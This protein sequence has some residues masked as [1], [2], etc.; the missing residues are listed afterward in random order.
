MGTEMRDPN[1]VTLASYNAKAREYITGSPQEVTGGLKKFIDA[2][3][4]D[5][6]YGS[7]VLEVEAGFGRDAL[8]LQGKGFAVIPTDGAQSFVKELQQ[9]GL[10]AYE[11]NI[12]EDSFP[13]VDV[14]FANAVFLH[15][16]IEELR[17]VLVKSRQALNL[18]GKLI[19]TVK[20]GEGEEFSEEKLDRPRYFAYWNVEN[21]TAELVRAGFTAGSISE[22]ITGDTTWIQV[23]TSS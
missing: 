20:K 21:I 4:A 12:L 15:L 22:D 5:V 9:R 11:L 10:P 1:A 2:A 3:F 19:F 7:T 13:K 18:A 8:Y 17:R 23:V 6:S 14:I 16:S